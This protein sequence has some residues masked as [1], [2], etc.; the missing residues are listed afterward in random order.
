MEN[1]LLLAHTEADGTLAKPALESLAAALALGGKVT[2]GLVG[3][4]TAAAANQIAGSGAVRF[5]AVTGEAFA[6]ARYATDAAAAEALAKTSGAAIV[7]APATSRWSRALPGVALR[8]G[9]RVDT[10]ATS[11]AITN[12]VPAVT[13]WF[14]RQ[15]MEAVLTRSQRPWIVLLDSGCVPTWTGPA[16][17]AQAEAVAVE[18]PTRTT[19]TG[20]R[21]PK[22]GEQTIRPD[23]KLLFV[24][25][26]GWT[27]KQADGAVHG[28]D[29]ESLILGF[30]RASK[31]S[32]GGSKSLVDMGG[33][34]EAVL[35]C[36]THLNQIGQ[37]GST[38]RHDKGLS[39]CCHGEE[40]HVV[41]WRFIT[42]RRAI[43]LDAN[44]GWARGKADV[45]Y[46]AD[47]FAVMRR[48]N[49]LMELRA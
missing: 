1:I 29:A 41:G 37:T 13:R 30:L 31:A 18:A 2:V 33:E 21:E 28:A 44:C 43:N 22:A 24:A 48:V 36:M 38:P 17:A 25:G 23:A 34:G 19:V 12:G 14:Y 47:A 8:L 35:R 42:Q 39:T 3:G 20:T 4:E 45:L 15:R 6:Q 40:P 49:E 27:K 9:G 26:A 5:L 32:L 11:L 10:H 7:L 46:V 16:G